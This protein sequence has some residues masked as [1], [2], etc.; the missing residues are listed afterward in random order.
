MQTITE[1]VFDYLRGPNNGSR[2]SKKVAV[3]WKDS[4][5]VRK[6]KRTY[7]EE[8]QPR[9]KRQVLGDITHRCKDTL[10]YQQVNASVFFNFIPLPFVVAN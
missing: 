7:T 1:H 5:N 10:N 4:Q 2:G 9:Y 6:T 8:T 3:V